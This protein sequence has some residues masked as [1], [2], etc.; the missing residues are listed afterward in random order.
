[1]NIKKGIILAGGTGSR[2]HPLTIATNKQL[3]PIYDKPVIYYPLTTLM[4]AGIQ[5][6]LFISTPRDIPALKAL[7]GDGSHLG[8]NFSYQIQLQPGGLPEAFILGEAF[9]D[10]QPVAMILGDNFFYAYGLCNLLGNAAR[11]QKNGAHIFTYKVEDPRPYGVIVTASDGTIIDIEEKP[12][13]FKSHAAITGLYYFDGTVSD[14]AKKLIPS[15]R[16]E[17][18]IVDLLRSYLLDD[19]LSVSHLGRGTVWFDVGTPRAL[20]D[21]SNY[22]QVMQD[23][24]GISIASPEEVAWRMEFISR[25]TLSQLACAIPRG[26]YQYY[27]QGLTE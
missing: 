6:I 4:L 15:A 14:R 3:L 24:Q 10:Q 9:I 16:K 23:R 20:L 12:K 13:D 25:D 5:D 18:E 27:L 21:A 8:M 17:L 11:E 7:F 19:E 1:M 2:L 26:K 22:V